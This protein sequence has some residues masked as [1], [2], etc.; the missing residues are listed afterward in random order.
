VE[1]ALPDRSARAQILAHHAKGKPLSPEVD[2]ARLAKDTVF[3]SGAMLENLLNEAA[4]CAA[5]REEGPPSVTPAD[6][7]RA[8]Y[9]AVAGS[10]KQD[11]GFLTE[12]DKKI[13]AYH[14]AGHALVAKRSAVGVTVAKVTIIPSAN[15][16]GG[17]CL[18]IP[19]DKPFRTKRELEAQIM[20]NLAGR[21]AEELIF[22]P[23][24]VTTGARSDIEQATDVA[25]QYVAAYG[26]SDQTGPLSRALLGAS[27]AD[28]FAECRLLIERLYAQAKALL[29][30][31]APGLHRL[32][33]ALL[34]RETLREEEVEA[35]VG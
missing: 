35:L 21:A 34:E 10:E 30:Q 4:I 25:R 28:L 6:V 11:R 18:N 19:P 24:N 13:T 20:I 12:G 5:K 32:S 7:E 8:Y 15:G 23:D 16:A 31:D 17:F 26:M 14:E 33:E 22:G 3:F 27:S 9:T 29:A 2:L 1:V